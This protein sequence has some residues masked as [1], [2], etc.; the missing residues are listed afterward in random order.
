ML[1]YSMIKSIVGFGDSWMYGNEI[2]SD[3]PGD[4]T[5]L[6][7]CILGQLG[8]NLNLPTENFGRAGS[9]LTSMLWEFSRWAQTTDNLAEHLIIVML[10]YDVRESWW[11]TDQSRKLPTIPGPYYVEL[12]DYVISNTI[13]DPI[14]SQLVKLFITDSNHT[15]LAV[16][17]YWQAVNFLDS[18]CNQHHIPLLQ[19]NVATPTRPVAIDSVYCYNTGM[20]ELL[21]E[22][23]NTPGK[24]LHAKGKHPN[25]AGAK[26]LADLLTT[27][28]HNCRLIND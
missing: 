28:I 22:Q 24:I 23:A 6:S 1:Q 16:M 10:T 11:P 13:V 9:S 19:I 4:P 12:N 20:V 26:F 3:A 27:E 25:Q 7:N 18:Y 5:R 14:W 21:Q 8:T 2:G 17:R 15:E